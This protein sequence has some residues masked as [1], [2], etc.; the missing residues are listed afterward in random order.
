ISALANP[1]VFSRSNSLPIFSPQKKDGG[2]QTRLNAS[3]PKQLR[4]N[5]AASDKADISGE[6]PVYPPRSPR[7]TSTPKAVP[8]QISCIDLSLHPKQ[9]GSSVQP[10]TT[11]TLPINPASNLLAL[12]N[13]SN[14][15]QQLLQPQVQQPVLLPRTCQQLPANTLAFPSYSFLQQLAA[16]FPMP[17]AV[18]YLTPVNAEQLQVNRALSEAQGQGRR[19]ILFTPYQFGELLK[20]YNKKNHI[21]PTERKELARRINLTE[22]Q[23]KIWFQNH[24]YKTKGAGGKL[25]DKEA[26]VTQPKIRAVEGSVPSADSWDSSPSEGY[27][28]AESMHSQQNP[29]QTVSPLAQAPVWQGAYILAR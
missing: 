2:K 26:A 4:I 20:C 10:Q 5:E 7:S 16:T 24:R 23:V 9:G 3:P 12:N 14:L 6:M 27:G 25:S 21:T 13:S 8:E 29:Q 11:T 1:S 18:P 17:N 28:T 15:R 19:R 22:T